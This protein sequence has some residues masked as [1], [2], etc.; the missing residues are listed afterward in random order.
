M[1]ALVSPYEEYN[2]LFAK[3]ATR[4]D[5]LRYADLIPPLSSVLIDVLNLLDDPD[6]DANELAKAISADSGEL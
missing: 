5:I 2:G 4:E 3:I 6:T 1:N